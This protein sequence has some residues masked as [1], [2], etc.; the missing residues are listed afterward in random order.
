MFPAAKG[1]PGIFYGKHN[2]SFPT[3]MNYGIYFIERILNFKEKRALINASTGEEVTF[4]Q[5]VYEVVNV[6]GSLVELGVSKGDLV[7]VVSENRSE[8][9]TAI[10][11]AMCAGASV[12]LINSAYTGGELL[13]AATITKPKYMFLSPTASDKHHKTLIK[14]TFLSKF[15]I[16]GD[17]SSKGIISY[18]DLA[19]K[20]ANFTNFVDY[21]GRV[22]VALVLYSSGTTGPPKGA[23]VTHANLIAAAQQHDFCPDKSALTLAPMCNTFGLTTTLKA[24]VNGKMVIHLSRF[25][26]E[27]FLEAIQKYKVQSLMVAPPL[28]VLMSKSL[29]VDNY[30]LRSVDIIYSGGAPLDKSVIKEIEKRLP[31]LRVLQGYGSTETTGPITEETVADHR[32]GSIGKVVQGIVMKV[33][34]I[35][36]RKILGPGE[37]GEVCVNGVVLFDGYIGKPKSDYFDDDGFYRTGDIAY[38][39]QD[40]YFFIIDRLKELIK[41][42]AWQVSPAEI[43]GVLL[44]HPAVKDAGVIGAPD[45]LT[46][47]LPTAFVVKQRGAEVTENDIIEFVSLEVSP[48]KRLRGGVRF[49]SEIPKTGSGKILRRVLRDM[50]KAKSKI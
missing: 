30:D 49:V 43:E 6:A 44:K 10:L 36:S 48:W 14:L 3:H 16:F 12:T 13:H 33:V 41:Y 21:Y 29:L 35:E 11:A 28:V 39:D 8:V 18:K 20:E 4:G 34:D 37:P 47:E 45:P 25:K 5:I 40:G 38:Y 15:F 2:F 26:E 24:L 1:A 9:L 46:G 17:S 32:Q 22:E 23:K 7:A 27:Q 42:K 50:L 31:N 19:K